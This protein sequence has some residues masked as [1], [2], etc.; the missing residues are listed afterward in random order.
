MHPRQRRDTFRPDFP[1]FTYSMA[2]PGAQTY[3]LRT[4]VTK[5]AMTFGRLGGSAA[6]AAAAAA[7]AAVRKDR[8][9]RIVS[10]AH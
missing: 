4:A 1:R 8:R 6:R 2:P 10:E 5:K 7:A 9:I 3:F